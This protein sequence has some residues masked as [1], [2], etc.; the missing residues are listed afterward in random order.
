MVLFTQF[1][2][3][4]ISVVGLLCGFC[5]LAMLYIRSTN[6]N[7]WEVSQMASLDHLSN[8][9]KFLETIENQVKLKRYKRLLYSYYFLIGLFFGLAAFIFVCFI[10]T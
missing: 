4:L 2:P 1:F 7:D 5:Y 10:L 9:K 3:V 8:Y 6:G